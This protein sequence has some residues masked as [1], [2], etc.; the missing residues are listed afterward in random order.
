[1]PLH[2]PKCFML[3]DP[4]YV[5]E[6]CCK[7]FPHGVFQCIVGKWQCEFEN[8]EEQYFEFFQILLK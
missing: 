7:L 4:G 6:G 2:G 8:T 1:M 5:C 3:C